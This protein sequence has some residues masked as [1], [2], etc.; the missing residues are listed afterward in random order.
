MVIVRVTVPPTETDTEPEL[1][2]STP[3]NQRVSAVAAKA[4]GLGTE[5][6]GDAEAIPVD[7]ERTPVE[8]RIRAAGDTHM[9]SSVDGWAAHKPGDAGD[10]EIGA[11]RDRGA[12]Q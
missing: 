7:V 4:E 6:D 12:G 3:A 10:G 2:V 9:V 5:A 11:R 1:G 8:A